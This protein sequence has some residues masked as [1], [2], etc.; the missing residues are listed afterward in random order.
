MDLAEGKPAFTGRGQKPSNKSVLAAIASIN[1]CQFGSFFNKGKPCTC[2]W[3]VKA[4]AR[5]EAR[6]EASKKKATASSSQTGIDSY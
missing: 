4:K 1:K 3:H 6:K 2:G 5:K